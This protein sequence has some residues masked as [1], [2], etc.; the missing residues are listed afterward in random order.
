MLARMSEDALLL[1]ARLLLASVFLVAAFAKLVDRGGA[2]QALL[3]FG[4]PARLA[5]PGVVAVPVAELAVAA[6]LVPT[7]SARWGAVGAMCLL[8]AFSAAIALARARGE[9][10]DCHCFGRLHAAPAGRATLA[11]NVALAGVT[12]FLL[13]AGWNDSG[14][15][16]AGALGGLSGTAAAGVAGGVLLG[17]LLA[18]QGWF[19]W[20]LLR[21]NGRL[22]ARVEAL[23]TTLGGESAYDGGLPTGSEAPAF[24][25]PDLDGQ[26]VSLKNLLSPGLPLVLVFSDPGCGACGPLMPAIGR[27]QRARRGELETAVVTRGSAQ[28][29][30]ARLDRAAIEPVLLQREHEVMEA[31]LAQGV[32]AAVLID[33]DGTIA[34]PLAWGAAGVEELLS[35][36]GSPAPELALHIGGEA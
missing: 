2:R 15:S 31:Y 23:E 20:Q 10:P 24:E 18:L 8:L 12:A 26:P 13:V 9:E 21:Q 29:N 28:E 19:C 35:M 17:G 33:P 14:A 22:I 5:G 27:L 4:V 3:G 25:L 11:R 32:P 16:V 7:G 1:A 36:A 6:A 30:I 34:S